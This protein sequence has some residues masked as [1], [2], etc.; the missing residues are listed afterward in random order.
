[1][2]NDKTGTL[3]IVATPIGNKQDITLRAIEVLQKVDRIA[4]EDTRHSAPLLKHFSIKKPILSMHEFNERE[5]F[6]VVL[7]Y[8]AAGESIALISDAG[9]PLI[10]DPGFHL[11][12]AAKAQGFRVVP[13]PG[14]CAAIAALS[15]AG[16]PTDKFIFEGFLPAK[17]ETRK[18]R[19]A[20]LL[21]ETR[22]LIF[23]EAPHR[24]LSALQ[25]MRE[26]LGADRNAV[27]AR[28]LTK[29]HE[30]VIATTLHELIAHYESRPGEQRGEI[31]IIV[32]GSNEE[33]QE[34]REVIPGNVLAI[35]L[36][37][38]P[39][40]QAVTLASKITGERKNVLYEVALAKKSA[41]K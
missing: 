32:Q 31:V 24:L 25:S 8:L 10:S 37:E 34:S 26:V 6:Q 40:K 12:R 28:E 38:L 1:M 36:E 3:Y 18:H 16:L 23:Y 15:V 21:H 35:L 41:S 19:L 13:L 4:A 11:V 14:V 17:S 39:L 7:D 2:Q 27:V 5:R 29:I 20:Q 33:I 9:T 22:T 30:S